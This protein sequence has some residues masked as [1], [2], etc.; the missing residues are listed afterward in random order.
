MDKIIEKFDQYHNPRKN[1]TWERH[2]FNMRNQ[3]P[4][5]S[6]N[7]YVTDLKTKAQTCEFAQL[8]DSLICDRIMCGITCNRT[9]ARLL[10]ES[11]LTLQAALNICRANEATSSKLKSLSATSSSKE[12]HH[13][14][15][16]VQKCNP[17]DKT[18]P[19]CDKCV[20]QHYCHQPCPAQ[21]VECYNCG[22]KNHFAKVCRTH[23]VTKYCKKV[24]SI[25]QHESSDSS[26]KFFIGMIQIKWHQ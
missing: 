15:F 9:R 10:K 8:K 5:E 3:Q 2:K 1:I 26:D 16:A 22:R 17:S 4:G 25:A 23:S 19:K 6:I 24:H 13:N 18:R 7:Q 21:G 12:A 11:M 14:V 20:N